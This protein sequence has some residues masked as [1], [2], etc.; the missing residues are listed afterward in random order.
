MIRNIILISSI[1]TL[2][3]GCSA[4]D[5]K[6]FN[7]TMHD[8]SV[9]MNRDLIKQRCEDGYYMRNYHGYDKHIEMC[10]NTPVKIPKKQPYILP[11]SN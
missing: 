10:G 11:G 4:H 1:A 6:L 5:Q 8:A 9:D 7:R 2:F 3:L